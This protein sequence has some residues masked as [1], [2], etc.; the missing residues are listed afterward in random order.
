MYF[1]AIALHR[2]VKRLVI[3]SLVLAWFGLF[4]SLCPMSISFTAPSVEHRLVSKLLG[5]ARTA[6]ATC[7]DIN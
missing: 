1:K 5:F 3:T 7:R 4:S 6:G 2:E